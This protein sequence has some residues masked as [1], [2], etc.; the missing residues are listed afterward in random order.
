MT[1]TLSAPAKSGYK[2]EFETIE[3]AQAKA[4]E[5]LG[6][7]VEEMVETQAGEE[8]VTYCYASDADADEDR[9]DGAYAVKYT[10]A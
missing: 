1:I 4:A 6:C 9:N 8:G 10:E 7:T 5:I 3:E 2:A